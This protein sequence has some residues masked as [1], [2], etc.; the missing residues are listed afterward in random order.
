MESTNSTGFL[1]P[2]RVLDL[3]DH[4][5]L[6]AGCMLGKLGADVI[7]VEPPTGSSARRVGPFAPDAPQGQNS[8]YWSAYASHKRGITCDVDR[9]EGRALLLRLVGKADFLIESADPPVMRDR[10]LDYAT[11]RSV[12]PGR[13]HVSIPPFGTNGPRSDYAG[14]ELSVWASAGP[15]HPNV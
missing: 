15:L 2:Y 10:G 7:Q 3:T 6:L 11:L 12:N 14:S 13:I 5:G 4:G 1:S 8:L 9:D